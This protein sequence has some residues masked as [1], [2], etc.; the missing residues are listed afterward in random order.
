MPTRDASVCRYCK[1]QEPVITMAISNGKSRGM[2]ITCR[3]SHDAITRRRQSVFKGFY[4]DTNALV[5][6][7]LKTLL[8][9]LPGVY[10]IDFTRDKA[11]H[12]FIAIRPGEMAICLYGQTNVFRYDLFGVA[13]WLSNQNLVV[14]WAPIALQTPDGAPIALESV[15]AGM[16]IE[17][18]TARLVMYDSKLREWA[19]KQVK[20]E[21]KE[22]KTALKPPRAPLQRMGAKAKGPRR[23]T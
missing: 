12:G 13:T 23:A 10:P 20:A 22:A 14:G 2:C 17:D 4:T 5:S 9:A 1:L 19:I 8:Q 15:G 3:N 11:R 18:I 16:P 21:L 6:L 7:N